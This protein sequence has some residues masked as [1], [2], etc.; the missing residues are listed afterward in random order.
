MLL[1]DT[2]TVDRG[3][4][5]VRV[6]DEASV[7][8]ELIARVLRGDEA[9]LGAIYDRYHRLIYAIALRVAGDQSSAEEIVQDVFHA[10]WRSAGSFRAGGSLASWLVGIARHRAID[11]TRSQVYRSRARESLLNEQITARADGD[12]S[13]LLLRQVVRAA[14]AELTQQQRQAIDLA[15]YGGLTEAQIAER[16][17]IPL[18][19]VK[20]RMRAGMLRLRDLL[21]RSDA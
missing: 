13:D 19:T 14:L 16:L 21:A 3:A 1:V 20:S 10:V 5:G 7:D 6:C 12:L 4:T 8:Q 15:Y 2:E 18:G 9:A 17:G 11:A